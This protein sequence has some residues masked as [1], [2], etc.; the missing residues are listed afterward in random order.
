MVQFPVYVQFA[1]KLGV[2]VASRVAELLKT[3]DLEQLRNIRNIPNLVGDI[4][5]RP[6]WH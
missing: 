2:L 3:Q 1:N 4:G 5:Q 6:A